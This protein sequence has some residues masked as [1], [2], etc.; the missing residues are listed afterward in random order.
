[1]KDTYISKSDEELVSLLISE[2]SLALETLFNRYYPALCKFTSI[3]IRDYNKAEELIADLFMKLWNKRNELQ[4]KSIKKYLFASAKNLS[5][6]EI[7]RVKLNTLSLNEHEDSLNYPDTYLNPHDL[8]ASR[9]SYTEIMD[10]IHLLPG[11]QR[12]V[13]LMS[14]IE[15][16]EKNMIAEILNISV[17][18]VE[19]LLYQAVKN[20]RYLATDRSAI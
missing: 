17:R 8:L 18:T 1:M 4:V 16:L 7:Q 13:L 10:L 20:F 3:Y 5:F 6:N 2:D 19:T 11:R 9:E 14:R 12:E 15:L